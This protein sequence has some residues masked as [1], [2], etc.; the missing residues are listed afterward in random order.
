MFFISRETFFCFSGNSVYFWQTFVDY[1]LLLL[2]S[3]SFELN[4]HVYQYIKHVSHNIMENLLEKTG[5]EEIRNFMEKK[6]DESMESI[7][8][9]SSNIKDELH[10]AKNI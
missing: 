10:E 7:C 8:G 4:L 9:S 1:Y 3:G 6:Q 5:Q 2:V